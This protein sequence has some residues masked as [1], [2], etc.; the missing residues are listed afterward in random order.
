MSVPIDYRMCRQTVTV[1][2]Y[3]NGEVLRREIPNCFLQWEEA[4]QYSPLGKDRQRNFLLIQPGTEQLVF[5]G[6]RI[7]EGVD[8]DVTPADWHK[9][10]PDLCPGVGE[11]SYAVPYRWQG[12]F[13]HTEAGRK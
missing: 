13:C 9:F 11:V 12:A 10:I 1:Y 5:P 8:L 4:E 6:D 3:V 7:Y 2:R